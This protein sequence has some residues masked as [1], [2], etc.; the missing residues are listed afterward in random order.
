MRAKEAVCF[1]SSSI[2]LAQI[3]RSSKLR[4]FPLPC[5]SEAQVAFALVVEAPTEVV[6]TAVSSQGPF[7][8][9]GSF[10]K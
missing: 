3:M 5:A 1:F 4:W 8:P 2:H 10:P 9:F 7:I 6:P